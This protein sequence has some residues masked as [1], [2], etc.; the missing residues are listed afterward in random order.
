[1]LK[2]PG[3]AFDAWFCL[4]N[5]AKQ[6][7][8]SLVNIP[9]CLFKESKPDVSGAFFSSLGKGNSH[10]SSQDATKVTVLAKR[11]ET[12]RF[13]KEMAA[14]EVEDFLRQTQSENFISTPD[15]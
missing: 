1:M 14:S 3:L 2:Q 4:Q 11:V 6:I 5:V 10:P 13:C 7:L 9:A 8:A 15:G 12:P